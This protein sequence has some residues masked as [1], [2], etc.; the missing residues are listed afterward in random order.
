MDY[1]VHHGILGMKWGIRRYQNKDGTLTEA[2]KKRYGTS[3]ELRKAQIAKW[4]KRHGEGPFLT[5]KFQEINDAAKQL[6]S[7]A[8]ESDEAYKKYAKAEDV[9]YKKGD[10]QSYNKYL[11]AYE[12]YQKASKELST[13][14]QEYAN[15]FLGKYGDIKVKS[16]YG[17]ETTYAKQLARQIDNAAYLNLYEKK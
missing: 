11:E 12:E 14:S 9:Y 15:Q 1:L 10:E 3:E 4:V 7:Y 17:Y 8:K 6:K 5:K 2:G 13:R 16:I